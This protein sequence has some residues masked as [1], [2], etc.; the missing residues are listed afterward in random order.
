MNEVMSQMARSGAA[1]QDSYETLDDDSLK[2]VHEH[3]R[4]FQQGL[5][6]LTTLVKEDL[7]DL[8]VMADARGKT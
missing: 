3:L 4:Q 7:S 2:E 6:H 1:F 8:Q 5:N